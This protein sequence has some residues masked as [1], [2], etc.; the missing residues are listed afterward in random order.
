M[1]LPPWREHTAHQRQAAD[2]SWTEEQHR[3]DALGPPGERRPLSQ[4]PV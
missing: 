4:L 3:R 2:A 1:A